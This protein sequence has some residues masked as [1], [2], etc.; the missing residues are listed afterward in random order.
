M[1]SIINKGERQPV[2]DV[3]NIIQLNG[4]QQKTLSANYKSGEG[5]SQDF[6]MGMN[7]CPRAWGR[8]SF[9]YSES[10]GVLGQSQALWRWWHV[11]HMWR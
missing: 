6:L 7:G 8:V 2:H 1:E 3:E 9:L 5:R 11:A 10:S 4:N